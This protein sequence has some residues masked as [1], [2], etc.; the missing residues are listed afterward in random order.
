MIEQLLEALPTFRDDLDA[1]FRRV[2]DAVSTT[3]EPGEVTIKIK[4]APKGAGDRVDVTPSVV[5]KVPKE[6]PLTGVFFITPEG[7]LSRR[8]NRQI[9][10]EEVIMRR[11]D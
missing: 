3:R 8:D 10:L 5:G 4:F 9:D 6:P 1:E 7:N 2:I 11:G